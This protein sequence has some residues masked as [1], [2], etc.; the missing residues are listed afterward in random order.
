[1][2]VLTI[3]AHKRYATRLPVQLRRAQ[4]KDAT[5]LLIEL[6]QHGAR[7]S[8][9]GG[10]K[11]EAGDAVTI[12]TP[13]DEELPGTIRWAHDGIAGVRL[14]KP[15]HLPEIKDLLELNARTQSGEP[16]EDNLRYGT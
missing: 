10:G 16:A 6:S 3:R 13:T 11:Y 9:L 7:I 5:G 2:S 12:T 14:D 1:M 8:N 15:L 4:R